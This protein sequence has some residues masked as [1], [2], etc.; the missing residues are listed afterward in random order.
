LNV[1]G[2]CALGPVRVQIDR[3]IGNA[4]LERRPDGAVNQPDF[5]AMGM[6]QFGRDGEAEA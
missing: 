6:H 2:P 5:A 1:S 3:P 4:E